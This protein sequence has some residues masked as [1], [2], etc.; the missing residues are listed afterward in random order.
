MFEKNHK[1]RR[2]SYTKRIWA[3]KI[4]GQI[5]NSLG[6]TLTA[7]HY[8]AAYFTL[9]KY[10]LSSNWKSKKKQPLQYTI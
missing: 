3:F 7:S 2:I 6:E 4:G 8:W 9:G 5:C 10:T 1:N